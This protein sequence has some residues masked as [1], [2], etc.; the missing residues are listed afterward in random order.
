MKIEESRTPLTEEKLD[1]V[2]KRLTLVFPA[3][4]RAFLLKNNGGKPTPNTFSFLDRNGEKAD[5]LLDDLEV[6]YT[7][8]L[9]DER[10][11]PHLVP[12]A[13]DPFG[14]LICLSVAGEDLGKVYFWD[15]EIEPK[16]AGY[17]NMSL[18][19]DSFTEFLNKLT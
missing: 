9:S 14:N 10:I 15:H 8:L 4:Y 13:N 18:I 2:Q 12:I 16:T 1:E 7:D 3:E 17:E 6:E 19:A 5:S 11:L